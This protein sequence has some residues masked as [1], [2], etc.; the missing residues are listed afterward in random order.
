MVTQIPTRFFQLRVDHFLA[1]EVFRDLAGH[2]PLWVLRVWM[3]RVKDTG[4]T[5]SGQVQIHDGTN[6]NGLPLNDLRT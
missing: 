6:K 4:K 1:R 3:R 5:V 2:D